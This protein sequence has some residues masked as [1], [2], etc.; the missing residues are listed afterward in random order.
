MVFTLIDLGQLLPASRDLEQDE[1]RR[2][3]IRAEEQAIRSAR[4]LYTLQK[5][6]QD[7][8]TELVTL[9]SAG[10]GEKVSIK[11]H[12]TGLYQLDNNM[13]NL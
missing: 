9:G 3:E 8:Q 7:I 5:Q 10:R 12:D 13:N 6:V 2:R 1:Q 11:G 4:T